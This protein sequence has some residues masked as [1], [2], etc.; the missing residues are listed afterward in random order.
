MFRTVNDFIFKLKQT[1]IRPFKSVVCFYM[2][3]MLKSYPQ[4]TSEGGREVEVGW[5][6]GGEGREPPRPPRHLGLSS[7]ESLQ[8]ETETLVFLTTSQ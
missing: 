4:W 8:S 6:E 2:P 5:G 7:G 3:A 1:L